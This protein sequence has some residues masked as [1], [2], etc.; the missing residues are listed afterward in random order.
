MNTEHQVS[1]LLDALLI[2][3]K[4]P[5][6]ELLENGKLTKEIREVVSGGNLQK[7][8]G[9]LWR[10][11]QIEQQA[12]IHQQQNKNE[13]SLLAPY[14]NY[15]N[16]AFNTLFKKA[17]KNITELLTKEKVLA[18]NSKAEKGNL[19]DT[20][21]IKRLDET[22]KFDSAFNSIYADKGIQINSPNDPTILSSYIDYSPYTL[23]Y[24]YY[25]SIPTLDQTIDLPIHLATRKA[26][27]VTFDNEELTKE[28]DKYFKRSKI[29]EKIKK[30]LFYSSLSPRGSL[31]VP[32]I[33]DT[34]VRFNILNDTQFTYAASQ[35]YSMLDFQ[36]TNT[37]VSQLFALGHVL[38]N[39]VTAH[40][41]CPGFEPI[42]A[43][44]KNRLYRLKEAAEAINIYLY[45]IKVL[46][47]RAQILVQ[48]WGGKGLN[49]TKLDQ[50]QKL[51]QRINSELSLSTALEIPEDGELDIL[52][53]NLS[54]GF[55]D[56]QPIIKEYQGMITGVMPDYFYG[57]N[58]AYQANS[59]NINVTHQNIRS[60]VQQPQIEPAIRFMINTVLKNDER[61]EKFKTELD[62]YD[63]EF[64]SM[65][66]MTEA[67]QAELNGKKID[68]ITRMA[69]YPELKDM[70]IAA[71]LLAEDQE[72]PDVLAGLT[73][74]QKAEIQIKRSGS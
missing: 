62:N 16:A 50:L 60:Q 12:S 14:I 63:V 58:N 51:T 54:P 72:F 18:F 25:L 45:T 33:E 55:A 67:E 27:I 2:L 65:Y 56:V 34:R 20:N 9:S 37:G 57:S 73:D 40:F 31:V 47:I 39:E 53:N 8:M 52:N 30:L 42:Y 5:V 44:G 64:E 13:E 38:Q 69:D 19:L 70:F 66:E 22:K 48:K 21:E 43:I 28:F 61:F 17:G 6:K 23:N 49:D 10:D 74:D 24:L 11:R 29:M 36:D 4:M 1:Q 71:D 46:C 26:P 35:Q 3:K 32:I 59:F 15:Q 7:I 68:N 41:L